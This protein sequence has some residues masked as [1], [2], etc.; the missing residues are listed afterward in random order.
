MKIIVIS[1]FLVYSCTVGFAQKA[2]SLEVL[3]SKTKADST[4]T[5]LASLLADELVGSNPQKALEVAHKGL[6]L[7]KKIGFERGVFENY[8]SLAAAQQSLALFDSAIFYYHKANRVAKTRVDLTG[9]AEIC[10]GLGHS[11]MRKSEMDSA[12]FY[13]E[14]GLS[15]AKSTQRFKIEAGIYN[16]YGN[17]F[18]EESNYQKALDYFIQAARLYETPLA[19]DQGQCLALSNIGNIEYRLGN[20]DK[21]LDYARQSMTIAKKRKFTSSIGYAHKLL[22]RIY[23]KQEKYDSALVEYEQGQKIYAALG[24]TRSA[25]ELLQNIGNVYFDKE[26]YRDAL[27]NYQQSL[28]L[29]KS[30][31]SKTLIAYAYSCI[32][33]AFVVLKENDKALLYL[34]SSRLVANALGN[35]YLVMD[36]YVAISSVYE[37]KGNYKK[38]LAIHQQLGQLK[39]SVT[40]SENRKLAE[41]TQAK[42]EL[43]KKEAKI[44][45]L[46]KDQELKTIALGRQRAIQTGSAI[47]LISIVVIAIQLINR[48]RLGNKARRQ[49]EIEQMRNTIARDLHDDIGST[50]SSINIMSQLALKDGAHDSPKK[51]QQI[52]EQSS[53][54]L[55][56]MSDI[57]WSINPENDTLDKVLIK[58]KEF[59]A[60]ILEPRNIQFKFSHNGVPSV[61][62]DAEKRKNLFLIF[63][64]A[65][66]NAAKYSNCKNVELT[67]THLSKA[68][69]LEIADDGKGFYREHV[70]QGNGLRNMEQRARLLRGDLVIK[71]DS[72]KGTNITLTMPIP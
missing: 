63:K 52:N 47:A 22:G 33:Q 71:S 53:R 50:L 54:V 3:L 61:T 42:Y 64:E 55:E 62:L 48:Y 24:D 29:A 38:A 18:L 40:K 27:K 36:S 21:A 43:E 44:T 68:I 25:A 49:A 31:S 16:N 51:F 14:K 69:Q 8:F 39:D 35:M 12:R 45:L 60:E 72:E 37:S 10:S 28:K 17:V 59:S 58:I 32:G 11:F 20:Y 26:K 70:K 13:L 4:K 67:F 46:E 66:N 56:S 6:S 15:L 65:V 7:A 41:E 19:D 23:K 2:D 1:F 5:I 30:L 34:D 9:Q 57:V